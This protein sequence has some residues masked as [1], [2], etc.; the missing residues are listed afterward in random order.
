MCPVAGPNGAPGSSI[1]GLAATFQGIL[2]PLRSVLGTGI[3]LAM[4]PILPLGHLA[5]RLYAS[6]MPDGDQK[7]FADP[8]MEAMFLD[9]IANASRRRFSA[10][11]HDV[12]LFGRSW[13]FELED[14]RAPVFWW[15]GDADNVI[16]LAHAE[17]S[18][19]LLHECKLAVR[20][21]ESHLGGFAAADVVLETL[22]D[23][24]APETTRNAIPS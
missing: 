21:T 23:A 14:I 1:V 24:W 16:P 2:D 13:G 15:H 7:V 5:L 18:V 12:T 20:E 11:A 3:W 6:R 10:V 4:Q 9:D 17:H 8:D 19:E 22:T